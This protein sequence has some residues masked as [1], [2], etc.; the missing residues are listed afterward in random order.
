MS[1]EFKLPEDCTDMRE[2]R[3]AMQQ[4]DQQARVRRSSRLNAVFAILL[5]VSRSPGAEAFFPW[6]DFFRTAL[7]V[8]VDQS[9]LIWFLAFAGCLWTLHREA[10]VPSLQWLG[11]ALA[12]AAVFVAVS[13]A[14]GTVIGF[15]QAGHAT[16]SPAIS[17]GA[18]RTC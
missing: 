13:G 10:A 3:T 12:A 1:D 18:S 6:V 15:S 2:V 7:V 9:V 4:I 14:S 8:H 16:T 11:L 17:S 5:V